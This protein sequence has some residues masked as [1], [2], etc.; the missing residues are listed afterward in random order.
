MSV[1]IMLSALEALEVEGAVVAV[2]VED[3][4]VPGD[5]LGDLREDPADDLDAGGGTAA[6]KLDARDAP[7]DMR[8]VLQGEHLG[9]AALTVAVEGA[10]VDDAGHVHLPAAGGLALV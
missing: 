7:L 6:D 4:D 1:G 5:V 3:L 8:V 9:E 10:E 2:A